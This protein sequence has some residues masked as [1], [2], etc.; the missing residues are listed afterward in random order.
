MSEGNVSRPTSTV[1]RSEG[2]TVLEMELVSG[3]VDTGT[4][5][6]R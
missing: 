6:R 3:L 2:D 5:M 4:K 1:E